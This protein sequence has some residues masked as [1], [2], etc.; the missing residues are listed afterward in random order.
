MV[1]DPANPQNEG[2]VFLFK[3]GK[4]IFDKIMSSMQPEFEDEDPINPFDFWAGADFKI[5]IKKV[6]GYWNYDSSEFARAGTLGDLDDSELEEIWKKEYSLAEIVA[7]EQ[8]K[9]YDDLKKRLDYVLGVRG[10]PKFQDPETLQEEQAFEAERSAP[11]VPTD[12]KS[13]L[14]NLS[15]DDDDTLSYFAKLAES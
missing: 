5:K 4:K 15:S 1:K 7:P 11:A 2:G 3:F 8:F 6:A 13:E 9:S 12:L 14:D 10:T